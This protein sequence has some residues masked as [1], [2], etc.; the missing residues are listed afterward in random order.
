MMV[1]VV[2]VGIIHVHVSRHLQE[3]LAW[4]TDRWLWVISN[5]TLFKTVSYTTEE[6][7]TKGILSLKQ[8]YKH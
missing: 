4:A 8:Y 1:N 7:K 5:I 2:Y 6:L 3:E